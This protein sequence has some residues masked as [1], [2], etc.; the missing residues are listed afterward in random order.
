MFRG[1]QKAAE[2]SV[3]CASSAKPSVEQDRSALGSLP[4][5]YMGQTA[6]DELHRLFEPSTA[7]QEEQTCLC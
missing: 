7:L 3:P 6:W 1:L 5:D 4:G 2:N